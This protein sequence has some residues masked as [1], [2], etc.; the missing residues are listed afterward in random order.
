[1]FTCAYVYACVCVC[2]Y[3][4]S[5]VGRIVEGMCVFVRVLY[6]VGF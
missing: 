1:M 3:A 4:C 2:M 6:V 5:V